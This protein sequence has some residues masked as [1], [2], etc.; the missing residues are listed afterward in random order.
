MQEKT[1]LDV[2]TAISGMMFAAD[3]IDRALLGEKRHLNAQ[4]AERNGP[5]AIGLNQ[6]AEIADGAHIDNI[7]KA[8]TDLRFLFEQLHY[9]KGGFHS[10]LWD[11]LDRAHVVLA[12]M[13]TEQEAKSLLGPQDDW[14]SLDTR[15]GYVHVLVQETDGHYRTYAATYLG[16]PAP[17]YTTVRY[18][19]HE[20]E[21]L[22]QVRT[23]KE[24]V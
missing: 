4:Q 19:R 20:I 8:R 17:L 14:L 1:K 21:A 23:K 5:F 12:D 3:S 10:S 22:K 11:I 2:S 18:A 6:I 15:L 7:E 9:L 16:D 13:I 24:G